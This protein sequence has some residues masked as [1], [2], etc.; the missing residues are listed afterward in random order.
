MH[1]QDQR[2][3]RYCWHFRASKVRLGSWNESGKS[4]WGL[5]LQLTASLQHTAA[6]RA[7]IV[8]AVDDVLVHL[9][10]QSYHLIHRTVRRRLTICKLQL[11]CAMQHYGWNGTLTNLLQTVLVPVRSVQCRVY[12]GLKWLSSG[13]SGSGKI[14]SRYFAVGTKKIITWRGG[15]GSGC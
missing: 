9:T 7:C 6:R 14:S 3:M 5:V 13:R 1:R 11:F 12:R 15:P 10:H 8:C 2:D 4:V